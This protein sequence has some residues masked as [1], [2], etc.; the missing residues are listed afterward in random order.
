MDAVWKSQGE[1]LHTRN[2]AISTYECDENR[3]IVEGFLKDDRLQETFAVTGE[4][5]P[6]GVIHHMGI[7]LLVN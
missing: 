1:K 3:I 7:R 6:A 5:F 4:T 2:I